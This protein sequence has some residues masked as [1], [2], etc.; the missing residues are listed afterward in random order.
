MFDFCSLMKK[1]I[2][3]LL[4]IGLPLLLC[5]QIQVRNSDANGY[6]EA[7]E[8]MNFIVQPAASG[9]VNYKIYYDNRTDP[10]EEGSIFAN[11]GQ[12]NNIPFTL[13]E[14]GVVFC[15]VEQFFQKDRVTAAFSPYEIQQTEPE[16][17]DFDA[18]WNARK[19]ELAAVPI[20]PNLQLIN[21]TQYATT[22][23]ISLAQ[24]DNRRVYGYI[25]V[26]KGAGPFPAI[27]E[28]P[29]FG[30]VPIGPNDI[31]AERAGAIYM[32]IV[33]HNAPAN[34][35][36]PNAYQPDVI[37]DPNQ[38]YFR[39]AILAGV[40]CID[41]LA[42]RPDWDG[43]NMA[44]T[45]DSQGGALSTMVAGLDN[46]VNLIS[47]AHGAYAEHAGNAYGKASGFPFYLRQAEER[48]FD[49][50]Q[51]RLASRYYDA[52]NFAKRYDGKVL[53]FLS[54]EDEISYVSGNFAVFN[55]FK[56]EKILMHWLP[57]GHNPSPTEYWNGR[58][59]WWRQNIPSTQNPPWPW[60]G[61]TT[62]YTIDA[63]DDIQTDNN[64][65]SLTGTVQWNT[66]VNPSWPLQ[67]EMVE[68]PG[69]VSFSNPT[70]YTTN[71]TFSVE[72]TYRLQLV[73]RD[74]RQLAGEQK[75]WTLMDD[76][77]VT[78]G[79]VVIQPT[80]ISL[81]CPGN[82]NL[83]VAAGAM[84]AV[85]WDAPVASTTCEGDVTLT[86]LSGITNNSM[87]GAGTY[88]I[89]YRAT[90]NCGNQQD[91]SFT[92]EIKTED[93]PPVGGGDY[94][95]AKG[96]APWQFWIHNVTLGSINNT[97][98]KDQ[99]GDYTDLSTE[100]SPGGQEQIT[101]ATGYSWASTDSYWRV[102]IDF[103]Q[104]SVFENNE[105]VVESTQ[106]G[107]SNGTPN[108]S[109]TEA[110]TIPAGAMEGSTRMRVVMST[111]GFTDACGSFGNGG[112]VEDYTVVIGEGSAPT[113]LT[114]NCTDDIE[115]MAPEGSNGA[116]VEWNAPTGTTTCENSGVEVVQVS[117]GTSGSF[118]NV[119]THEISYNLGDA[120]S[121]VGSCSFIITVLPPEV[122][123]PSGEYCNAGGQIP[124]FDWIQHVQ[125]SSINNQSVKEGYADFTDIA[126]YITQGEIKY[127][128]LQPGNKNK[129]SF[130][131]IYID[132]NQDMDFDDQGEMVLQESRVGDFG[133]NITIPANATPGKTRMRIVMQPDAFHGSCGLFQYGEVEDYSM[134]VVAGASTFSNESTTTTN[135]AAPKSIYPNP[136]DGG[137]FVTLG[138]ERIEKGQLDIYTTTGIKVHSI[139][140]AGE[141]GTKF[142]DLSSFD[143]GMYMI[144]IQQDKQ[145]IWSKRIVLKRY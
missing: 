1:P 20:D 25:S 117:G 40:R 102:W 27:I 49:Y 82:Q 96:M 69:D 136:T 32:N 58:Y 142:V 112:E 101:L 35:V 87:Q 125:I 123:N 59:D 95:D 31:V 65:V 54:Y 106:T 57:N 29:A 17:A 116:I 53:D 121:N 41:Y 9:M 137:V 63:G 91:C 67:W 139:N 11:Q 56:N 108:A 81:S 86:Q 50:D 138:A 43:V 19:A 76:V 8:Q 13:N 109:I 48:G 3:T 45:G 74:D 36:D 21:E 133:G 98:F 68:G 39:W 30:S 23:Q 14:P 100:V 130:W 15:E 119:G 144:T 6:Y 77:L 72:G 34:Q 5:A 7:G 118:F 37:T 88:V 114:P 126:G 55:Q 2:F 38:F 113:F 145:R 131:S 44:L 105:I 85:S 134:I 78:V 71:A 129:E 22:Y 110:F 83:T 66:D 140:L 124:W 70:G 61:T 52:I 33:I 143:N 64:Q 111:N 18:F 60:P 90:D 97:S 4:M 94:C 84:T 10:V 24:I 141:S 42:T 89:A 73:A 62:G 26:P 75:Y 28:F 135:I 80:E 107:V 99:Y 51:V 103:N 122:T 79:D 128:F 120:C 127:I 104:N 115:V 92:I 12:D 93:D 16:P 132:F 47:I 46:R